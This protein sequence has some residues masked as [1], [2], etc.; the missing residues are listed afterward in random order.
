MIKVAQS[1]SKLFQD[2]IFGQ[3][4]HPLSMDEI[5]T[6]VLW[7]SLKCDSLP[8]HST[9]VA[10]YLEGTIPNVDSWF[11]LEPCFKFSKHRF[12]RDLKGYDNGQWIDV[13]YI[14]N[15][16]T[17]NIPF[18]S[19]KLL[20]QKIDHSKIHWSSLF[21]IKILIKSLKVSFDNEK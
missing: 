15:N 18:C 9:S 14:P 3:V 10:P 11:Q 2:L 12:Y 8:W 1:I 19:V 6:V 16:D 4:S 21:S 20:A 7:H 17:Q 13:Q 5:L